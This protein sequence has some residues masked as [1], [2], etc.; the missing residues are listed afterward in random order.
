MLSTN[1]LDSS[2]LSSPCAILAICDAAYS[3]L[4]VESLL[5]GSWPFPRHIAGDW[6]LRRF[7][8]QFL[9]CATEVDERS[10]GAM[11]T[12][13]AGKI[14]RSDYLALKRCLLAAMDA[15]SLGS[16]HERQIIVALRQLEVQTKAP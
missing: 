3:R 10:L 11:L 12:D 8:I 15:V 6:E 1:D 14:T 16:P 4:R 5:V 2:R 9:G 13:C 7:L